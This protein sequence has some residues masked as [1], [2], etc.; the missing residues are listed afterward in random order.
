MVI[1]LTLNISIVVGIPG[2]YLAGT[3]YMPFLCYRLLSLVIPVVYLDG[4]WDR[5]LL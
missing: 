1:V 4:N 3:K 2:L 5:H